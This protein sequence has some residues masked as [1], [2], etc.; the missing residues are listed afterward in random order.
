VF[1][2]RSKF[3]LLFSV[4]IILSSIIMVSIINYSTRTGYK[5]FAHKNDITYSNID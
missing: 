4:I 3:V 1:K 2:L 5:E